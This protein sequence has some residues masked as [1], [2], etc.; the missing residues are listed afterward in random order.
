MGPWGHAASAATAVIRV[1]RQRRG[2]K[3]HIRC[4]V[5]VSLSKSNCNTKHSS[6]R[7]HELHSSSMARM[8][9]RCQRKRA[10]S[11]GQC[12]PVHSRSTAINALRLRPLFQRRQECPSRMLASLGVAP[13]P[14]A[15][16]SVSCKAPRRMNCTT[17]SHCKTNLHQC[18]GCLALGFCI[19]WL[20]CTTT[21]EFKICNPKW[22]QARCATSGKVK[23]GL[24]LLRGRQ[25]NNVSRGTSAKPTQRPALAPLPEHSVLLLPAPRHAAG[26]L[27]RALWKQAT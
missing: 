3:G 5:A 24:P 9:A 7:A 15:Y 20:R 6:A 19:A 16:S 26:G 25:S 18:F 10:S 13:H 17:P 22:R 12:W 8:H 1:G 27:H 14:A 11:V 2:C 23:A 21:H 4:S